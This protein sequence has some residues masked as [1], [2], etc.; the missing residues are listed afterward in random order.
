MSEINYDMFLRLMKADKK[1][2]GR[3]QR[4][5]QIDGLLVDELNTKG[6]PIVFVRLN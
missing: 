3:R 2:K 1:A 6:C 5:M 4:A